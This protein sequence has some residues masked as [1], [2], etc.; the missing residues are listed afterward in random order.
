MVGAFLAGAVMD[1]DWFDQRKMDL[2]R[3]NVL[4][5]V[6]P[7][8]FLS[9]GLRTAGSVGGAAVFVAAALLLVASVAG[10]LLA[11]ALAGRCWAG[12]RARLSHRLA[13]ADQGA[14]HDHLS[15]VLLD[16]QIITSDHLHRAAADG[17]GQHH[18]DGAGGHAEAQAH[19]CRALSISSPRRAA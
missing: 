3:H 15:N 11:S 18:A 5:V 6:M 12:S 13:A 9:T 16:K 7:V 2:L 17:G 8:F 19:G 14:D 4:L 10:K 1:A